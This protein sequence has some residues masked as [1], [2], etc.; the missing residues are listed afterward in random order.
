LEKTSA[1]RIMINGRDVTRLPPR[2]RDT[3]M[4]FQS[5]ARYP[6]MSVADN[7]AFGRKVRRLPKAEIDAKVAELVRLL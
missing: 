1:G 2:D 5:Y 3:A 4:V 7:I 6:T